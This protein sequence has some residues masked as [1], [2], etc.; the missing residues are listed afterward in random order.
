MRLRVPDGTDV[1]SGLEAW[2]AL[3]GAE[4]DAMRAVYG[5][6]VEVSVEGSGLHMACP[7][8]PYVYHNDLAC[9]P[10]HIVEC[11][12]VRLMQL[13]PEL[14]DDVGLVLV[15]PAALSIVE[16]E[17]I[18]AGLDTSPTSATVYLQRVQVLA[19]HLRGTVLA[20]G[21]DDDDD[22]AAAFVLDESKL[23]PAE[24]HEDDDYS[25]SWHVRIKLS[26]L[27]GEGRMLH[28]LADYVG[29]L[30][31]RDLVSPRTEDD[32]PAGLAAAA[33][34]HWRFGGGAYQRLFGEHAQYPKAVAKLWRDTTLPVELMV[35]NVEFPAM[36]EDIDARVAWADPAARAGLVARRFATVVASFPA[37]DDMLSEVEAHSKFDSAAHLLRSVLGESATV[38]LASL[39]QLERHV[40]ADAT[41]APVGAGGSKVD[42][43]I[44]RR[45]RD[46]RVEA[47]AK[48]GGAGG[49]GGDGGGGG[50]GKLADRPKNG[51]RAQCFHALHINKTLDWLKTPDVVG[52]L[53][54]L[55]DSDDDESDSSDSSSDSEADKPKPRRK[56]HGRR[57]DE[58]KSGLLALFEH[59]GSDDIAVLGVAL[60][61]RKLAIVQF[62]LYEGVCD[63]ELF[64]RLGVARPH[65]GEYIAR[66]IVT[67]NTGGL[68]HKDDDTFFLDDKV[69]EKILEGK[70]GAINWL[71]DVLA[72]RSKHRN[73][74]VVK[75]GKK[76]LQFSTDAKE[77]VAKC[78]DRA[79]GAL[80][81]GRNG[82]DTYLAFAR[83]VFEFRAT[84]RAEAAAYVDL[85]LVSALTQPARAWMAWSTGPPSDKFPPYLFHR[86][87]ARVQFRKAEKAKRRLTELASVYPSVAGP[88]AS[89]G[90]PPPAAAADGGSKKDKKRQRE[91]QARVK[92]EDAEKN[93]KAKQAKRDADKR[94]QQGV[95]FTWED[96]DGESKLKVEWPRG[97]AARFDVPGIKTAHNVTG[98]KCWPCVLMM[99]T[100]TQR[101]VVGS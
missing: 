46:A 40:A 57:V 52:P 100:S 56:R 63:H 2:N 60:R 39:R 88:N 18:K 5:A 42:G 14:D 48:T 59:F 8:L 50:G 73:E 29:L 33:L 26:A 98:P 32:E 81:F 6:D 86:S 9:L 31:P 62:L 4:R 76:E 97:D 12:Y 34:E 71:D 22:N 79:I 27:A 65:L 21:A 13:A 17:A 68:E 83:D 90:K 89:G 69:V 44:A 75:V 37:L 96:D 35:A 92:K 80:G 43:F 72:E 58:M 91:E 1:P 11:F 95:V 24:V 61:R 82:D 70:W 53:V 16:E 49:G 101:P 51:R 55:D 19:T 87:L 64:E 66:M 41:E 3:S 20:A 47:A 54:Y 67:K 45:E 77:D 23:I 84:A 78:I 25:D 10:L 28:P 38:S 15:D 30:G 99:A 36:L 94:T 74:P 93:R 85:A 7:D